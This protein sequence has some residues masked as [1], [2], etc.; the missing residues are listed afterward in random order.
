MNVIERFKSL[1]GK[2]RTL[3]SISMILALVVALPLFIWAIVNLNFN[4]FKKAATGEPGNPI[5]CS[6]GTSNNFDSPALDTENWTAT[7]EVSQVGGQLRIFGLANEDTSHRYMSNT[8]VE[9]DFEA[10]VDISQFTAPTSQENELATAELKAYG[11]DINYFTVRW[12][13]WGNGNSQINLLSSTYDQGIVQGWGV[14]VPADSTPVL[15]LVRSGTRIRGYYDIGNGFQELPGI[16]DSSPVY[17][18]VI[19]PTLFSYKRGAES[20][21][22]IFD[23]FTLCIASSPTNLCPAA[24]DCRASG[25]LLRNCHPPETDNT[26]QDSICGPTYSGRVESCGSFYYCCNGTEWSANL[27]GCPSFSPTPTPTLY[28]T[29]TP[30][31]GLHTST[32][33]ATPTPGLHTSTPSPFATAT[34]IP[35]TPPPTVRGF[36]FNVKLTGVP[37]GRA[38]GAKVVFEFINSTLDLTLYTPPIS[39]YHVGGGIYRALIG[40]MS[41]QLPSVGD[42][43]IK[44]KG[45]KHLSKK[46]CYQFGQTQRCPADTEGSIRLPIPYGQTLNFDFTGM[47]LEPGDLP[48]QDGKASIEDFAKIRSLLS[49]PCA[50]LTESDKMTADVDYNGCVNTRDAFLMRKSLETRYDD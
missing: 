14:T 10:T 8:W 3:L 9:G 26:P 24:E 20:T 45:E 23:N 4:P 39:L 31:P 6:G 32:P 18:G 46:F 34:T 1:P 49:K 21:T 29:P 37:D 12:V 11:D 15:K 33:T 13:K 7:D 48:P 38:E 42:Y 30:T 41:D 17:V 35:G 43:S 5:T 25:Q 50:D 2:T 44:A 36:E 28:P 27:S 16:S 40:I 47:A 22:A 19:R